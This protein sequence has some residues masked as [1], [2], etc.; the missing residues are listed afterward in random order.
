MVGSQVGPFRHGPLLQDGQVLRAL[1]HG[2]RP[3]GGKVRPGKIDPSTVLGHEKTKL[4]KVQR[5]NHWHKSISISILR[6]IAFVVSLF[7]M[8]AMGP[9]PKKGVFRI[10]ITSALR[11]VAHSLL[12]K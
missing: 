12:E 5:S 4:M 10:V 9:G 7:S 11:S 2:R 8:M 6:S 1:P 3:R